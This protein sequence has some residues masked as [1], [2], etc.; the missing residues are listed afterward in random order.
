MPEKQRLSILSPFTGSVSSLHEVP[1]NKFAIKMLGDGVAVKPSEGMV[2]SPVKG[3]IIQSFPTKHAVTILT[4]A[5]VEIMIHVGIDTH[6]LEG[7]GFELHVNEKDTVNAG[8]RLITFDL[9]L[10]TKV[11]PSTLSMVVVVNSNEINEFIITDAQ[12]VKRSHSKLMD[13][14]VEKNK[15]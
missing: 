3:E 5:N 13:L 9:D 1:K 8:D 10:I 12:K 11:L 4:E 7:R 15:Q 14:I 2:A 6:L